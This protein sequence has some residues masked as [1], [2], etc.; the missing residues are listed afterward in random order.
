MLTSFAPLVAMA[1]LAT[2]AVPNGK[3]PISVFSTA[4]GQPVTFYSIGD[5]GRTKDLGSCCFG[6]YDNLDVHAQRIVGELMN[7][8]AGQGPSPA[9]IIGLGDNMYWNGVI[10]PQTRDEQFSHAFEVPYGGANLKNTP[11]FA[12]MGNHD[13]GGGA[14]ICA[15]STESA[16]CN[17][18]AE[19]LQGLENKL[20]WMGD[21]KSLSNNRWSVDEHFYIR[22][23]ED[24]ASG[25]S[26]EVYNLDMNDASVAGSHGI[27]CQCYGY[28]RGDDGGCNSIQRGDKYCCGGDTAMYD[29]CMARFVEWSDDS[30][31]QMVAYA[32]KSTATWKIAASHY[33]AIQHFNQEDMNKWLKAL[34]EAGILVQL[35]GH[36]H[37]LKFELVTTINTYFVENGIGGGAKKEWASTTPDYAKSFVEHLYNAQPTEYGFISIEATTDSLK[38]QYHTHDDKWVLADR[39]EDVTIGGV[40]T[41]YC[42]HI[43][44]NGSHGVPC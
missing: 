36:T 22:R 37:G 43:P 12:L 27:C 28:A 24:A 6:Q 15:G 1:L 7:I 21:Y 39:Y 8:K 17:S 23:Y 2:A 16:Q 30:R 5:F 25:V 18:T 41:K 42:L 34:G 13:Y 19:L 3:D 10:S 14:F 33:S 29:A 44:K 38:L 26:V 11:M 35:Y 4:P 32:S 20:R 40:A 9:A 31:R